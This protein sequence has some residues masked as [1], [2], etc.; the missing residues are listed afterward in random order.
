MFIR[1]MS[2]LS[3][4]QFYAAIKAN[5]GA[6]KSVFVFVHGYNN[7]F[8]DAALRT[9][10]IAYDLGLPNLPALFS[11]SS[12]GRELA[13]PTDSDSAELARPAFVEFINDLIA[14]SDAR[15]L[16]ILGHSMG[17]RIVSQGVSEVIEKK[18]EWKGRI[19]E[20]LLAAADM[21]AETFRTQI[22][23]RMLAAQLNVTLYVSANDKTLKFSKRYQTYTRVGDIQAGRPLLIQGMETIDASRV[24]TDWLAHSYFASSAVLLTDIETLFR[25]G[26]RASKRAPLRL[27][28]E[29]D[30]GK[31]FW[32]FP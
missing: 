27:S 30:G 7:T 9:A 32:Y 2:T 28:T 1:E 5:A 19:K 14:K 29:V 13:Y 3:K 22:A 18:P 15:K 21:N 23:P 12:A 16:Y 17:T 20:V 31:R 26:D 10:Q 6:E 24:S 8:E 4:D 25:N 11:W